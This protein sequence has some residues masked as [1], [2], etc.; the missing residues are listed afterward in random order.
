MCFFCVCIVSK[1]YYI[2]FYSF[3]FIKWKICI[4]IKIFLFNLKLKFIV[5]SINVCFKEIKY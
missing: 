5:V 3:D 4:D 2:L 1:L